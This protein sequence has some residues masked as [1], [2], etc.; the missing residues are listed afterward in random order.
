M[1]YVVVKSLFF[2]SALRDFTLCKHEFALRDCGP[3]ASQ[4][5]QKHVDR[6]S[7]S[8]INEHCV[9]YTYGLGS[10]SST[11]HTLKVLTTNLVYRTIIFLLIICMMS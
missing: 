5:L 8:L 11:G 4:F 9:L 1:I 6:M 2:L 10:C 3:D 7:E